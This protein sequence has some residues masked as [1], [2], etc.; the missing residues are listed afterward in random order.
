MTEEERREPVATVAGAHA[1][2]RAVAFKP[3]RALAPKA[4][5]LKAALKAEREAF[6]LKS[7]LQRVGREDPEPARGRVSLPEV[8]RGGKVIDLDRCGAEGATRPRAFPQGSIR[9]IATPW[10]PNKGVEL[11]AAVGATCPPP[12]PGGRYRPPRLCWIGTGGSVN[13]G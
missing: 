1:G 3:R 9:T 13:S 12:F 6:R 2:L 11:G 7:E 10:G 4:P 8:L 5:A